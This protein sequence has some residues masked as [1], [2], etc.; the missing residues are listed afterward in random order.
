[1]STVSDKLNGY[2]LRTPNGWWECTL[3]DVCSD[4]GGTIQTGPFG[5]QLHA[6]DYKDAGTPVVMPQQLGD[7]LISGIPG[8]VWL[9]WALPA[10]CDGFSEE[11]QG[12]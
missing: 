10:T 5:S 4:K 11:W 6:H 7:N 12:R 2:G 8:F 1:M 3:A 9:D